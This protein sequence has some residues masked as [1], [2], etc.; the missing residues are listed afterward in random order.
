[1]N[2][3]GEIRMLASLSEPNVGVVTNVGY[4]HIESFGSVEEIAA[5]KRELIEALPGNGTAVLNHDDALVRDFR[6]AHRGATVTFGISAGA[7]VRAEDV[8]LTPEES[9][10]KVRGVS[11]A[12]PLTGRHGVS[13]ILAGIAVATVF[14]IPVNELVPAVAELRP[15][16]MRGERQV[17]GGLTILNDCYNSNPDA[18]R[19]M[20]DVLRTEPARR[21]IAV[22]GEMLELGAWSEELHRK[23]GEYAAISGIDI[24]LGI[25][26]AASY[27]VEGAAAAG[28][29]R[30]SALFFHEPEEAGAFLREYVRPGDAILFKGSRGTHV[31]RA[32]SGLDC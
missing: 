14:G 3:A 12:S 29:A 10:F 28:L 32:L 8:E 17:R 22:L 21:R 2:H 16:R 11:F 7:G 5:A 1:M 20:I 4:A 31:E 13:N 30:D 24:V 25:R 26:G 19:F 6:S 9:R 27:L 23:V 18:A 15:G